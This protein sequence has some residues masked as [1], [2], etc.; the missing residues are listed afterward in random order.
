[1]HSYESILYGNAND[2]IQ[3]QTIIIFIRYSEVVSLVNGT[4]S[5]GKIGLGKEN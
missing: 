3:I 2:H 5:L 1:M 4:N